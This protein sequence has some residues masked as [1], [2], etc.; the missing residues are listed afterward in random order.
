MGTKKQ[1]RNVDA[2]QLKAS[3]GEKIGDLKNKNT[4][5]KLI[6]DKKL[7]SLTGRSLDSAI[8]KIVEELFGSDPKSQ[9]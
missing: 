6:L 4:P 7:G 2:A 1:A 9:Q 3:F 8:D 5:G